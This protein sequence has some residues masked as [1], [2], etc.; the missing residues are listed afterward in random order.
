MVLTFENL[1][2]DARQFFSQEE[3]LD[4]LIKSLEISVEASDW[5]MQPT[6]Q[7]GE[8]LHYGYDAWVEADYGQPGDLLSHPVIV[9]CQCSHAPDSVPYKTYKYL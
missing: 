3:D 5:A 6:Y 8:I 9:F 4:A 1:L 2:N 7:D